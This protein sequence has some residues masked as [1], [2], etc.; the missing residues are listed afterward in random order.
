MTTLHIEAAI[1]DLDTWRAA[2]A[3]F[4]TAR[5]QAGVRGLQVQQPIDDPRCIIIDLTFDTPAAA[6]KFL[7]FLEQT[8]W[9][10]S[11]NAPALI[12]RPQV[13]LF[14]PVGTG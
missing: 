11:A 8:V 3:R 2:F 1:A 5:A 7:D 4:E 6:E 10:N 9:S 12:G 14:E 13:R